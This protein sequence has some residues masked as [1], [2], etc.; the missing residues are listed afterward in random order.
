MHQRRCVSLPRGRSYQLELA[1]PISTS[2]VQ[3]PTVL[4]PITTW[5]QSSCAAKHA[6]T[7]VRVLSSSLSAHPQMPH[8]AGYSAPIVAPNLDIRHDESRAAVVVPHVTDQ[9]RFLID[10]EQVATVHQT[11]RGRGHRSPADVEHRH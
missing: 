5:H 1:R 2:H 9:L 8:D 10:H 11:D 6:P 7:W 4:H 3:C